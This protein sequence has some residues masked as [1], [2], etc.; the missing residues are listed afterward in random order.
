MFSYRKA[1]RED[2][3]DVLQIYSSAQAFMESNG[4]PQWGRGF[5]DKT[6][7]FGGILGGII[8]VVLKDGEIAAV[9][10]AVNHEGNYDEIEGRWLSD[11][12]YLAVHRVAVKDAFRGTGA[13]KYILKTAA[14]EIAASR[15]RISIR[16]DTHEKNAPMLGLLASQEFVRCGTVHLFRDDSRRVAFEKIIRQN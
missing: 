8:Y 4:N 13:A 2:L 6:D 1:D 11:G 7:I 5:P 3:N 12:N 10:S 15:G 16:M 9:F 14:P